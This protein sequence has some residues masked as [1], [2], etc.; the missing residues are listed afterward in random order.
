VSTP[1]RSTRED[2]ALMNGLA[3]QLFRGTPTVA[4]S[5]GAFRAEATD[6]AGIPHHGYGPTPAQ[7][8]ADMLIRRLQNFKG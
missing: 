1:K 7:A 6:W 3:C 4:P 8:I 5:E 2:M